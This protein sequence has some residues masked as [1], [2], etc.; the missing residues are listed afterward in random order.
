ML[1]CTSPDAGGA[2][3]ACDES[4]D[5]AKL[6]EASY[7]VPGEVIGYIT[8]NG[9]TGNEF[10]RFRDK[11]TEEIYVG[12]TE[13]APEDV[14]VS[15]RYEPSLLDAYNSNNDTEYQ[16]FPVSAVTIPGKVTIAKGG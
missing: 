3:S 15:F 8:N 11:G 10:C 4:I 7:E 14:T 6:D 13:E 5:L 16:L 2:F 1:C 9:G 12:L